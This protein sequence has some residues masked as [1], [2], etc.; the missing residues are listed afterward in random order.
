MNE[1]FLDGEKIPEAKNP[2]KIQNSGKNRKR[3]KFNWVKTP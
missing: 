3:V 1:C 2:K